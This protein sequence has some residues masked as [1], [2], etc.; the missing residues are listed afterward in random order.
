MHEMSNVFRQAEAP[1]Q[2]PPQRV[3]FDLQL[4]TANRTS[5]GVRQTAA[6]KRPGWAAVKA[7]SCIPGITREDLRT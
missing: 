5:D 3:H 2:V 1:T 4:N 6:E 7:L